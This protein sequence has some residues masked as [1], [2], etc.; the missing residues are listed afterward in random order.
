MTSRL[1]KLKS[2][3]KSLPQKPGI[4]FFLGE[5][6]KV[7]YIGKARSLHDRVL[8]YFLPVADSKVKK[9]LAE[10][11]DI[12]TILTESE[13]EAAF[14]ESNFI[15]EYQP[16]FNERLKDDKSFPY[17]KLTMGESFPGI[18][19]TRRVEADG[20]RYFGPFSPAHQAR[21]TIL[22]LNKYFGIRDCR[23]AIPGRRQ[24]PCLQYDLK[25]CSAPCVKNIS[26][27]EYL[28]SVTNALLFLEGKVE[29][30][31]KIL[32]HKMQRAAAQ[33]QYEEA[34]HWR[35]L[36]YTL[37][38]IKEKP[39]VISTQSED[40]DIFG[41]SSSQ[42]AL[43][44]FIFVMRRG[45]VVQSRTR[46][47]PHSS[48]KEGKLTLA[49]L[50]RD[51]YQENEDVPDKILL[52]QK[53]QDLDQLEKAL[54]IKKGKKTEI[55]VPQRGKNKKLLELA[56][57]NA[58]LLLEKKS[59]EPEPLLALQEVLSL[60]SPPHLIEGYDISNTGG[61][62]SVGSRVTFREGKPYKNGYRKYRI[63]SVAGPNDVASLQEVLLRRF[64]KLSPTDPEVPDLILVDGGKGQ[65]SAAKKALKQIG[66]PQLPLIAIAK[67]EE[68]LY[69]SQ[70]PGGLRL[71]RTSPA[72]QLVQRIRDES[73]RFAITFH[74]HRRAKKSFATG[75]EGIPG[76][77]P[78]RRQL[79]L[80]R[81]GTL[82][83][84]RSASPEELPALIGH[85]PAQEL[86]HALKKNLE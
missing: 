46:I 43:A 12:D 55:R 29:E 16:K 62:E 78:K 68:T 83:A 26:Q 4:Y 82:D 9:I 50:I 27:R 80:D 21:K 20:A 11:R 63:R 85:K 31:L 81:Y 71:E 76:I 44:L 28:D 67:K 51:F 33:Q 22:L 56:C 36:I 2:L 10:T 54:N 47:I 59:Q 60:K 6:N 75:L 23:E 69:S 74:R 49:R 38:Q 5:K 35:D 8:S 37:E 17:L 84:I 61:D 19:L 66:L 40:K 13:R 7:L 77:G 32:Q 25:L 58:A 48:R 79:L 24:R 41:L 45:K 14:L 30:L 15:Q 73:H 57:R 1:Q 64:A 3:A 42:E 52:P 72:L 53:P 39:R 34:A 18:Y 65:W 86:L 70:H